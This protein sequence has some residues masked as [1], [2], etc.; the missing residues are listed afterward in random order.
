MVA[1]IKKSILQTARHCQGN[2]ACDFQCCSLESSCQMEQPAQSSQQQQMLGAGE[3]WG[4]NSQMC[5]A[6][7]TM[8]EDG[9]PAG[10][11]F[12]HSTFRGL[13]AGWRGQAALHRGRQRWE[14][15]LQGCRAPLH[16][17]APCLPA[18]TPLTNTPL[19][20]PPDGSL[21]RPGQAGLQ[22]ASS[23]RRMP[24][25]GLQPYPHAGSPTASTAEVGVRPNFS[26]EAPPALV[27]RGGESR[28]PSV[29]SSVILDTTDP[30][31]KSES[32]PRPPASAPPSILV[33]PDTS[34][35]SSDKVQSAARGLT[36]AAG[37]GACLKLSDIGAADPAGQIKSFRKAKC[38]R[39]S[40]RGSW[41]SLVQ[42]Q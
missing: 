29:C 5:L 40:F 1:L 35:N 22:A 41:C 4:A 30:L 3:G 17:A 14:Y 38:C 27:V 26:H 25:A 20:S 34:R 11:C 33:K 12:P 13:G 24:T 36:G 19:F 7:S 31:A 6:K 8:E 10:C 37:V 9:K 21:Q 39:V 18:G 16:A 2:K 23:L 28:A 32:G 42:W 15:V